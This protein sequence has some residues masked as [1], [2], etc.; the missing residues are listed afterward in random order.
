MKKFILSALCALGLVASGMT[1]QAQ[2][3]FSKGSNA[4]NVGVALPVRFTGLI[5]PPVGVS[6]ERSITDGIFDKGSIGVGA[7]SELFLFQ[8]GYSLFVGAR[9]AA[10]YEF[11]PKLDTYVALALGLQNAGSL[12]FGAKGILGA[13]YLLNDD[14][15]V[16]GEFG[17]NTFAV[18]R[19][20]ITL[21]L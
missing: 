17:S 14:F 16:F 10:H 20:G 12:G 8:G 7:D 15:G 3:T 13:R 19:A 4:L 9:A 5:F 1:A 18:F 21:S 2:D 11:I 6:Y